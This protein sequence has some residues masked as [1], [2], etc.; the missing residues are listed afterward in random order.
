MNAD[1]TTVL[2]AVLGVIGTLSSPLLGQRIAARAKQQEFDLQRQERLEARDAARQREAFEERRAMYARINTSARQ[3]T[4][5]LRA[6]LRTLRDN[7]LTA[8][9]HDRLE[10]ARQTYRDFYSDAQM[11]FPDKVLKAAVLVNTSLGDAYGTIKRLEVGKPQAETGDDLPD[12]FE[13]VHEYCSVTLYDLIDSLRQL[14]R[15]DLGVA[16]LA[17][18]DLINHEMAA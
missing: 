7:V 4:Q 9:E 2:V 10:K 8:E 1:L 6:Y 16:D 17:G 15:E 11:I 12:T 18:V 5:E 14:M 13:S 3:Y